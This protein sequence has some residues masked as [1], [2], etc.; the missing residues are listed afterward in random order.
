MGEGDNLNYYDSFYWVHIYMLKYCLY[1][2]LL[3][4]QIKEE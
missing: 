3:D 1:V 4:S 2:L